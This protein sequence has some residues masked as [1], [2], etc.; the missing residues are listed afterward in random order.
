MVLG[1]KTDPITLLPLVAYH[2]PTF[3]SS[4][5]TSLIS[6]ENLLF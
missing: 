4:N 1:Q 2:T 3:T 6:V 5:D